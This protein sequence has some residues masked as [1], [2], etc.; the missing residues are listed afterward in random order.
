M[1]N[2]AV[3]ARVDWLIRSGLLRL[4]RLWRIWLLIRL[5]ILLLIPLRRV[6]LLR[7]SRRRLAVGLLG[8]AVISLLLR[9][10]RRLRAAL[11]IVIRG[12]LR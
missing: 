2:A 3:I 6:L 11:R 9:I 5:L 1:R 10:I 7:V 4:I 12:L 8:L